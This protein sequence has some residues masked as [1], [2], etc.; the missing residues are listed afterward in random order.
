MLTKKEITTVS[1]FCAVYIS[2]GLTDSIQAPFYPK[3]ASAKGATPAEYGFVFGV[4]HLAIFI[5]GPIF[6]KY[7]HKL[8][9]KKVYCYGVVQTAVCALL[10][11]TLDFVEDKTLFLV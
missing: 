7:M 2:W 8:G 5:C 6:G 11:G 3:E 9:V 10:F 1:L 4:I